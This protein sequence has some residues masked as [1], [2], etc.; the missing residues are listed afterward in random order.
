MEGWRGRRV[1]A[2]RGVRGLGEGAFRGLFLKMESQKKES[3]RPPP[4]PSPP[5]LLAVFHLLL[6]SS[7]P[8]L[9]SLANNK[10]AR[11]AAPRGPPTP[12]LS[13]PHANGWKYVL[14]RAAVPSGG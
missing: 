7:C 14:R 1:T 10:Y 3:L 6:D 11:A 8:P 4:L 2:K 12:L 5:R 9:P 13:G